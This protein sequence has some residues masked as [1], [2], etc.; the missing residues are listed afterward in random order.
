MQYLPALMPVLARAVSADIDFRTE[1][2]D[3]ETETGVISEGS[4]PDG[5]TAAVLDIRG[6]GRKRITLNT[7]AVLEKAAALDTVEKYARVLG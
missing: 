6:V 7:F 3:E 4:G 1:D 2:V 5:Q